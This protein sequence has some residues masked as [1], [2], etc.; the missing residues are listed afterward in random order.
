LHQETQK[1]ALG[2]EQLI[3][4]MPYY[5]NKDLEDYLLTHDPSMEKRISMLIDILTGIQELHTHFVIHRDLKLKNIF[6]D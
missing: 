5:P 4:Y 6:L 3:I 1:T 2:K